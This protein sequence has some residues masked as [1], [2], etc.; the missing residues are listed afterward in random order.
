MFASLS[1]E[2]IDNLLAD[3]YIQHAKKNEVLFL[4][5]EEAKSFYLVFDGWVKLLRQTENGQESIIGVFTKGETFA[6]AAIFDQQGF[7]VSAVVVDDAEL[8]VIPAARFLKEFRENGEY[9]LSVVASMSRHMRSLVRQIE[10]LSVTSSTE[11]LARFLVLLCP[12]GANE[13][14]VKFPVEKSLVAGRLGMQPETL[15]RALA[16][17]RKVGVETKGSA[18]RISNVA[19]LREMGSMQ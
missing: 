7:P 2:A 10:Q 9:A 14:E 19:A 17:L 1:V 13:A 6:E 5:G 11:R 16:K 15:S 18:V 3:A 4:R 8:L 12:Q